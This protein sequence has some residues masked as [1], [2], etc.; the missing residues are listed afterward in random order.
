MMNEEYWFNNTIGTAQFR[1]YLVG[2]VTTVA[3]SY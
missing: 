1:D 2:Y 3:P